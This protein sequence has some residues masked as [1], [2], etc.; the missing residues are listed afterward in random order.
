MMNISLKTLVN[1]EAEFKQ[2]LDQERAK[3]RQLPTLEFIQGLE[4]LRPAEMARMRL[5]LE[6]DLI[7]G[8]Q[9]VEVKNDAA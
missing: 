5:K 1:A 8:P 6:L 4:N 9:Q 2:L 7:L 3:L